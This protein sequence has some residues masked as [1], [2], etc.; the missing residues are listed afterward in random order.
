[1]FKL[2]L[3]SGVVVAALA[4]AT[5]ANPEP[6]GPKASARAILQEAQEK[7]EHML[8]RDP[9]LLDR[10]VTSAGYVVF[11]SVEGDAASE[12]GVAFKDQ[13]PVGYVELQQASGAPAA[14]G[15]SYAELV[16]LQGEPA[17]ERLQQGDLRFDEHTKPEVLRPG[18]GQDA[19]SNQGVAVIVEPEGQ[20]LV[21]QAFRYL[22]AD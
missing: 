12:L 2:G 7:L 8:D 18:I 15:K 1:M 20:P 22:S 13:Q 4:D 21:G 5:L 16:I 11:P 17:L 19:E 9:T 6:P 3:L 10:L 14:R